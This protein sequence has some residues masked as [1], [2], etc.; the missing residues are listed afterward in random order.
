MSNKKQ[1]LVIQHTQYGTLGSFAD[2][3]KSRGCEIN[4]FCSKDTNYDELNASDPDL[5]VVLGGSM[6]TYSKQ[7]NPWIINEQK[8]VKDRIDSDKPLLGICFG[9]QIIAQSLGSKTYKGEQ[10]KEIGWI[11][12]KVNEDGMKT[13][14]KHLDQAHTRVMSWHGDTFD[15]PTGA[16]LLASSDKYHKQAY[17]YGNHVFAIQCHPEVTIDK[18]NEIYLRMEDQVLE[19]GKTIDEL[20]TDAHTYNEKLIEQSAN[21]LNDWLDEQGL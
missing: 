16:V 19:V 7:E 3:L 18:L 21:F 8:F 20:R 6:A 10:G 2:V 4:I 11:N 9:A 15:L 17:T 1:I 12:I 5:V 13:P 14:F